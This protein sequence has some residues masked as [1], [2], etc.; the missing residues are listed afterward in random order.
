MSGNRRGISIFLLYGFLV[1]IISITAGVKEWWP[2]MVLAIFCAGGLLVWIVVKDL[3][4][5]RTIVLGAILFR[6]LLLWIPPSLSDD[7]YR[8]LWDGRVQL[9]GVNPYSQT[10]AELVASGILRADIVYDRLN[11]K[12]LYT[13]YPPVSQVVFVSSAWVERATGSWWGAYYFL[14]L[15]FFLAEM[16]AVLLMVRLVH[17]SWSLLYA[18]HPLV[19]VEVAGQPHTEALVVLLLMAT[20]W[21]FRAGRSNA[22]IAHLSAS[23][24]IKL[25][26]V[27]LIPVMLRRI[28]WQGILVG[29]V[30]GIL[31]ALP[32]YQPG[33]LQNVLSSLNLY[34]RSFEFNAGFYYLIKKILLEITGLD[35]SKSIG[36]IFRYMF[37]ATVPIIWLLDWRYKWTLARSFK[38]ILGAF[39]LLSTTVHPWYFLTLLC[40]LPLQIPDDSGTKLDSVWN[41]YAVSIVSMGTYLLYVDGWYWVFVIAGWSL[42]FLLTLAGTYP[43]V[44]DWVI[45]RRA[46]QKY[47]WIRP[48]L[49]DELSGTT[50]LDLGA[51]EGWLGDE[52]RRS[53]NADVILADVVDFNKTENRLMLYDGSTLPLA[54]NSVDTTA[55]YFVLHHSRNAV[56][57][58]EEA[59]RVTA[60][61]IIV[62]ESVY[63]NRLN[64]ALLDFFDRAA[65]RLRSAGKMS[66]QEEHL[67]FR[68]DGEWQAIFED[69]NLNI[70]A[71]EKRGRFIHRQVL[72]VLDV[73]E[74]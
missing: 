45:R 55:I 58:L 47:D 4:S 36:P 51:G 61:R 56:T 67:H 10:P 18:W 72:Y 21:L 16:T 43:R 32:F 52:V 48:Y 6:I 71:T 15:I 24:W 13:V 46:T 44:L 66:P 37:Y 68:K 60:R 9:E 19:L 53:H 14:K 33:I 30:V 62:V 74:E 28:R 7:F 59:K 23:V 31:L 25:Y 40:L 34:T 20:V 50:F 35:Y 64:H 29:A 38:W 63:S 57:V 11:S 54:D 2:V 39:M 73:S 12:D 65:N 5:V 3:F 1:A 27:F 26:P 41:W 8:Y 69:S 22:A 49:R 42:W 17:S 70:V